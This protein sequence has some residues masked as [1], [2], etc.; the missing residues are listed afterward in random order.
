MATYSVP[1]LDDAAADK[2]RTLLQERLVALLDLQLTL[3]HIHWN[4]IG[5]NFIG[6]HEMLD[7]HTDAVRAMTDE[8]A[9]RIATL[10]GEPVGTPGFIASSRSWDE[11]A[12]KRA[13]ATD[14]LVALNGVYDG[15][16]SDHRKVLDELGDIDPVS[17]DMF[18]GQTDKLELFQWFVRAHIENADG[19]LPS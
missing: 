17:E 10:G 5:P 6:V 8:V 7:P 11:Y 18:I 1:G 9:E 14:H 13:T 4:V 2:V 3:K 12:L 15:L 16:I 19:Q